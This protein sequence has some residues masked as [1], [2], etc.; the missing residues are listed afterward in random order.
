MPDIRVKGQTTVTLNYWHTCFSVDFQNLK[1]YILEIL[2]IQVILKIL[3][4]NQ[5]VLSYSMNILKF[6]IF[7]LIYLQKMPKLLLSYY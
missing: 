3:K 6:S 5:I 1:L 4:Y 7:C 2:K